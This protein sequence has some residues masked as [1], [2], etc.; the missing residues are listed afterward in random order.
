[1]SIS[2]SNL[3]PSEMVSEL[4]KYIVGQE[5]AKK[6]VSIAL[7]NRWRRSGIKDPTMKKEILPKNIL[8]SGPTGVGKTE[9]ARRLAQITK[10]PLIKVEATKFT[11]VGYIGRDVESIIKDLVKTAVNTRKREELEKVREKAEKIAENRVL[12]LLNIPSPEDVNEEDEFYEDKIKRREEYRQRMLEKL[13]DGEFDEKEV[14]I[15]IENQMM[16]VFEISGNSQEDMDVSIKDMMGNLFPS[17]K[18]NKNMKVRNAV[19]H[20]IQQESQKMLDMDK[21]NR[22]AL[23]WTEENGIVFIDEI[24]KI[25]ARGGN[26][27]GPDVSREGVQRDFLPIVEGS[28]VTTKFGPIKTDH[29]LFIAAGA[30]HMV[31]PSDLIPELQ[32]RF[33]LSVSLHSLDDEHFRKILSEPQC[34]LIKQYKAL[35]AEEKIKLNFSKDS[36]K[37]IA[38]ISYELNNTTQDIGARRLQ[39][40]LETLLEEISFSAPDMR[41]K[42]ITIT[43]EYVHER[44]LKEKESE[45]LSKYII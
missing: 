31:S 26:R 42:K 18:K 3:T 45:K 13:R 28:T 41:K 12:D 7:R 2:V 30:F 1:M 38:S 4:D 43:A 34:S 9:I 6:T 36:V 44:L 24:D 20:I 29:I 16:P 19:E 27:S 14:N 32:G 35:I 23:K 5:R 39:M 22:E 15:T 37:A 21:I 17:N 11:E 25:I 33:P 10:S 8:M 40:V